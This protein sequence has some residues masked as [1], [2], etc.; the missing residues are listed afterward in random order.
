[1]PTSP[2]HTATCARVVRE[3]V[4]VR[5]ARV[6]AHA[7]RICLARARADMSMACRHSNTPP[8]PSR[9]LTVD[10][11]TA[12]LYTRCIK[13]CTPRLAMIYSSSAVHPT[14]D[15]LRHRRCK[16][17]AVHLCTPVSAL[18]QHRCKSACVPPVMDG[19]EGHQESHCSSPSCSGEFITV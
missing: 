17:I 1:M 3:S 6:C 9:T 15:A 2:W 18:I 19:S 16:D 13:L 10:T 14:C 5:V 7:T 11:S 12:R 8:P 4:S